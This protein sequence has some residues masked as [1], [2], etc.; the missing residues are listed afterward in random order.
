MKL[1]SK[2]APE[3]WR[4]AVVRQVGTHLEIVEIVRPSLSSG[5]VLISLDYS[6]VCRSQLMEVRGLR[7]PDQWTP[8]LLGHEGVGSVA[9]IGPDVTKVAVG[10]HVVVG[11]IRGKGIESDAPVL[12]TVNGER[13]NAGRVT[14]FSEYTVVSEDRVYH[15]PTGFDDR[16]AVL[17]GC[18][19][20]T[21]AGM[22]LHEGRPMAGESVLING[23]GG[24]GLAALITTMGLRLD[25]VAA[26]PSPEKRKLAQTLGVQHV[27]D[28]SERTLSEAVRE[29]FPLGV[30]VAFDA[31]GTTAGIEASFDCLQYEGGRLVFASHPP[32]GEHISLDPHDLIK[33]RRIWGSWG[34]ACR[35]DEDIPRVARAIAEAGVNLEFMVPRTYSLD[36][37]NDALDDLE[38]MRAIRPILDLRESAV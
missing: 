28:P 37:V 1:I 38:A 15:Q 30:D 29:H 20:P 8:H 12:S 23:L 17:F 32:A 11:W 27:V 18:A 16:V 36:E 9:E 22:V 26:E 2:R 25:V 6:G 13:V 3:S 34:G 4:A 14:T 35:P 33:G 24:V 21:G 7:G 10:D 31:S 19:L 5:Q